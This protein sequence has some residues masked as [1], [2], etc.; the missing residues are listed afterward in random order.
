MVSAFSQALRGKARYLW[1]TR[2]YAWGMLRH[3]QPTASFSEPLSQGPVG[4]PGMKSE[5]PRGQLLV[6]VDL[7]SS[8]DLPAS[9]CSSSESW[10]G[11]MM[12]LAL[13]KGQISV[14]GWRS[15]DG[16]AHVPLG[17]QNVS[18]CSV[19]GNREACDSS[20]NHFDPKLLK[21]MV[22]ISQPENS[23]MANASLPD[24][25]RFMRNYSVMICS[26]NALL[27]FLLKLFICD[28]RHSRASIFK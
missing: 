15:L 3:S 13:R 19:W 26:D 7:I 4:L 10:P 23:H 28:F 18:W 1:G 5:S 2:M 12:W 27:R 25:V 14:C 24:N 20:E 8:R 21:S 16:C 6:W 11:L 22:K 9:L 17:A